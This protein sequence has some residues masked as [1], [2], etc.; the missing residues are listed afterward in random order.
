MSG[1]SSAPSSSPYILYV[2]TYEKG[3]YAFRYNN[4]G[5]SLEPLGRMGDLTNPSWLTTD[6]QHRYLYAVSELDGDEQGAVGAFQI[7]AKSGKL[8]KLNTVSSS[9]V[10]PCHVA[11]DRT[12]RFLAVANYMS[13]SVAGFHLER[14]GSIG[15]LTVLAT[16][17]GSSVNAKRQASPHAHQIVF[18]AD[19][20]F[21]YVPDLGIDQIRIYDVAIEDGKLTEHD[22]PSVDEKAG[23]G[24]RHMAFS[25][26]RRFA[27]LLNE[28]QSYVTVYE[29]DDAIPAFRRIQDISSLPG[30]PGNRD[31]AAEILVHPNG[32]FV[33]AS[34]R[35]PG[36]VAVYRRDP[37]A[38]TLQLVQTAKPK[39]TTPRGMDFNP[40]GTFL[41]VG[42][43]KDNFFSEIQ[44]NA[45][46]GELHE[47]GK[48]YE[49][50]SPVSFVFVAAS[51]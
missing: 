3:I 7:D 26:D 33:Y 1:T 41:L 27:Y 9:G 42:D 13:G 25:P 30:D 29:V 8:K 49:V 19:D 44:I 34:N 12:S 51:S 14:D 24:P 17:K 28:L 43:Q 23:M 10:A 46:T 47:N 37:H 18:S 50:P 32:N 15:G 22:P 35:G 38:G 5:P 4:N 48:S 40:S 11:V 31:G 2:G 20:R 21:L 6:P 39:G 16:A 36:T 45:E